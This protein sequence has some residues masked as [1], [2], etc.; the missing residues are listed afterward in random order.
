M[1][2]SPETRQIGEKD[3][4]RGR[5]RPYG[6]K[7]VRETPIIGRGPSMEWQRWE[8]GGFVCRNGALK[9]PCEGTGVREMGKRRGRGVE[10]GENEPYALTRSL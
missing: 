10:R 6:A 8:I 9:S 3:C 7:A 1:E 4:R 5:H 2:A